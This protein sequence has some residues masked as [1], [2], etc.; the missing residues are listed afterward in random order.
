MT[1]ATQASLLDS[2]WEQTTPS[3]LALE[4]NEIPN[5]VLD[6]LLTKPKARS[7]SSCRVEFD[8]KK[9]KK[10]TKISR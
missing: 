2:M 3:P 8:I 1:Y 9:V 10:N 6:L 5:L 4:V 7:G